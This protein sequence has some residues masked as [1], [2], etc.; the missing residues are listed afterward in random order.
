MADAALEHS[1]D[2]MKHRPSGGTSGADKP[3]P[4]AT[5]VARGST[6]G[7]RLRNFPRLL[8]WPMYAVVQRDAL[9]GRT[10]IRNPD[11]APPLSQGGPRDGASDHVTVVGS[12]KPVPGEEANVEGQNHVGRRP[13]R[14]PPPAR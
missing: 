10:G 2:R 8:T 6:H 5:E 1:A 9:R 12:E 7:D 13:R 3:H 4:F 14:S 11:L